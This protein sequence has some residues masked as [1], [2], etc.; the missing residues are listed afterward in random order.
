MFAIGVVQKVESFSDYWIS[1]QEISAVLNLPLDRCVA[2]SAYAVSAGQQN[3]AFKKTRLFDP[4][5]ASHIAIAVQ[6]KGCRENWIP[7]AARSRK[8]CSD[9]SADWAFTR[10]QL[11]FP[12][13]KSDVADGYA[14]D[15]SDGIGW[16]SFA[17]KRNSKV[18]PAG[19]SLAQTRNCRY[20][21]H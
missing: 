19:P 3:R 10:N 14:S 4:V 12:F 9:A 1:K 7:I 8:N 15:V 11:S 16:T 5:D 18:A 17:R 20:R 6:I 21:C 13:D 2:N